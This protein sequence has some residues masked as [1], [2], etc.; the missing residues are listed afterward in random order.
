MKL[1][2]N[3][4]IEEFYEQEKHKYPGVSLE[5]FKEICF[6][7]WRF[8][9]HEMESGELPEV[10][11]KYFGTFQ[12]YTGRAKNMLHNLKKRFQFHKIDPNDYNRLTSMLNKFLKRQDE[13][14]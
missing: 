12:V 5:Q 14:N 11:L 1:Q 2:N 10:R 9:K 3:Q 7:P 6:G 8:L 13:V 4:L